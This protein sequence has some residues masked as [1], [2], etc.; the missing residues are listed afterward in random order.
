MRAWEA[1]RFIT[2]SGCSGGGKS[3]L[4]EELRRRGHATVAEPGRRIVR[5]ESD[6]FS[7]RLPWN[8]LA[9]FA[10]AA[11]EM[12][13]DD[14]ERSRHV[15]GPVFFDRGLI[16][17]LIA[18]EHATGRSPPETLVARYRYNRLVFFTPP[19]REIYLG[20]RERR[21]DFADAVA[22]YHRLVRAYPALGYRVC[23]LPKTGVAERADALLA[24]LG[25]F[26]AGAVRPAGDGR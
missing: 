26:D 22:E 20:D 13:I 15:A 4:L 1:D 6:P 21:H 24:R 19:W 18:R 11:I 23:V 10:E 17:A 3:T 7:P 16:D 5:T 9:G 2:I 8:D 12:A 25:C 14:Y